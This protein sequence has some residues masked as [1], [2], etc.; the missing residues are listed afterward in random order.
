MSQTTTGT[1]APLAPKPA[2]IRP[3]AFPTFRRNQLAT[4]IIST[5]LE[6]ALVPTATTMN[7]P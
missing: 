6:K 5:G 1:R 3:M 4:A 7:E 2:L